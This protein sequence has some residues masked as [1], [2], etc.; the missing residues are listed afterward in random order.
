VKRFIASETWDQS[1]FRKLTPQMKS[2]WFYLL[3]K[4]D[5]SGVWE[6]DFELASFV[7]G[8]KVVESDMSQFGDRVL[9]LASG[10]WWLT[11]FI[12]F[13]YGELSESCGPHKAVF[14]MIAKNGLEKCRKPK[15][16]NE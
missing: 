16:V 3:L 1:W 11:G 12:R 6:P 7:I 10:K 8:G 2:F 13:Q 9:K 15:N 5:C 4:V 14:K